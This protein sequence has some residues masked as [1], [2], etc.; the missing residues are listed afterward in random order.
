MTYAGVPDA[1]RLDDEA[2]REELRQR[3][4]VLLQ[5][6]RVILPGVQ[7]LLAFLLTAPFASGY[8]RLDPFGR[9][10]FGVA[11]MSALAAVVLLMS[12]AVFHRVGERT[13]RT[14]RLVWGI[15]TV[16]AGLV[17]LVVA[18]VSAVWCISRFAFGTSN[19]QWIPAVAAV[20][21]LVFWVVVPRL[22]L[23]SDD[24]GGAGS[25]RSGLQTD[26]SPAGPAR[27][28][29]E[30]VM[31]GP[32]SDTERSTAPNTEGREAQPADR[33]DVADNAATADRLERHHRPVDDAAGMGTGADAAGGA[34]EDDR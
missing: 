7:V 27:R 28:H 15:R 30:P 34:R 6:L 8:D 25:G 17:M 21:F 24:S 20:M 29:E 19:A 16:V 5:E 11:M 13:A 22:V 32:E 26:G 23:R 10:L 3:Y 18:L 2:D 9:D 31:A 33:G 14:L 12:P 4:E 1:S